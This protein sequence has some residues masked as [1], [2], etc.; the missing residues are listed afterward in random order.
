[1]LVLPGH[2]GL[3]EALLLGRGRRGIRDLGDE[4]R[5]GGL[6]NAVQEDSDEGS[7]Q[8]N[9]KGKGKTEQDTLTVGKPAVSLF[10][11]EGNAAKVGVELVVH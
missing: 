8:H 10:G 11:G 3:C 9:C 4:V 2:L 6:R 1:M 5:C 7:L